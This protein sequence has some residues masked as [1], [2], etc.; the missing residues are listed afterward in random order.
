MAEG[1]LQKP[2]INIVLVRNPGADEEEVA[3]EEI[4]EPEAQ[5]E[6]N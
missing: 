6:E 4:E 2:S 1:N 5:P 3:E